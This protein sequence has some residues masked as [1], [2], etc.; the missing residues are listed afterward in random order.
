[1]AVFSKNTKLKTAL[2]VKKA[3]Y[4][5]AFPMYQKIRT[6]MVRVTGIEPAAS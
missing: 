2:K 4:Y 3:Q 5:W 1:M 6:I